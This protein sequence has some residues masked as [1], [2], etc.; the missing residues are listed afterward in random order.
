MAEASKP[1]WKREIFVGL[2]TALCLTGTAKAQLGHND[3]TASQVPTYVVE[4]IALGSKVKADS[5]AYREYKCGPSDQFEGF[6]WCQRSR[7]DSERR[8]SFEATY[9][10]LHSKDGT[11]VYANR[12]QQPALLDASKADRDIQNYSRKLGG[13]PK[14]TKMPRQSGLSDAIVA[15]WGKIE[16]EPLDS[17]SV[18]SLAEGKSPKKGLLIDFLGNFTRSA[19]EGL[20]IYRIVGGAGFLW[21]GSFDQKGRGTLRFA[22]IDASALQ[23]GPLTIRPSDAP[24]KDNQQSLPQP[25]QQSLPQP[26]QD[27]AQPATAITGVRDAEATIA[28]LQM[29]LMA[30]EKAKAEADIARTDAEKLAQQA[31]TDAEIAWKEY[32]EATNDANAAKEQIEKMKTAAGRPPSYVKEIIL[33]GS[34]TVAILLLLI[35]ILSRVQAASSQE[36]DAENADSESAMHRE[37]VEGAAVAVPQASLTETETSVNEDEVIKQLAKTLGVDEPVGQLSPTVVV[38]TDCDPSPVERQ[39]QSDAKTDGEEGSKIFSKASRENDR[40]LSVSV[41][42]DIPGAEVK[43]VKPAKEDRPSSQPESAGTSGAHN[44]GPSP[45]PALPARHP[46]APL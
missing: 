42:P 37:D 28:R 20:P 12:T 6:T 36:W 8:R 24:Q 33:I 13:P 27:Q 19:H 15:T 34:F 38:Y 17:E 16:L 11:V 5:S 7:R 40:E 3:P 22:T 41:V 32:E 31:R 35:P 43:D 25:P 10:I 26:L 30:T 29:K 21:A 4:G 39:E 45:A 46:T 18:R 44:A 1:T 2:L 23:P 14:I 9:S